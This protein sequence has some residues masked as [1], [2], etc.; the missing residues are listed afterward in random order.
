MKIIK[1]IVILIT[2]IILS[3]C[4][5]RQNKLVV[6]TEASFAP[7]EY[8]SNGK[9]T[10]VDIAIGEDIAKYLGKELKVKDVSFDSIISEI[11]SGKSDIGAAGISYTEERA[12]QVNFTINYAESK[13]VI[14]VKQNSI[15]KEP[16]DLKNIKVA[17]QLGSVA[18]GYLEENYPKVKLIREKKFLAAIQDLKDNK[19]E[20]VVMDELPAQKYLT[21]DLKILEKEVTTDYY[22]MVINKNNQELLEAANKVINKLKQ[23]GKIDEYI[24]YHMERSQDK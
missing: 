14:I 15:I 2:I 23:E 24:L 4:T 10:G 17:V 8:Y 7:Y 12:K 6:V 16:K 20:A 9:I 5:N 3:G 22:G 18:D 21:N 13:Q 1:K 19:V 11:K